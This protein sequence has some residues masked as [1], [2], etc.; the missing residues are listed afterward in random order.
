MKRSEIIV[1]RRNGTG[2]E[3]A[4]T[5]FANVVQWVKTKRSC[6]FWLA[7]L[8]ESFDVVRYSDLSIDQSEL[9]SPFVVLRDALLKK[10]RD[11]KGGKRRWRREGIGEGKGRG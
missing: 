4:S 10:L 5:R 8:K 6:H 3:C 11:C 7:S 1:F 9:F 2:L